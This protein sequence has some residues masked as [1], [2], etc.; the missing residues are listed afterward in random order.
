[1]TNNYNLTIYSQAQ[2]EQV[3]QDFNTMRAMAVSGT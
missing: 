2:T 3:A 1:V